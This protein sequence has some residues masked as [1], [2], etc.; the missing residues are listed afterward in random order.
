MRKYTQG[1]QVKRFRTL[2][3]ENSSF[4]TFYRAFLY[5]LFFC[6]IQLLAE[7][8][9]LQLKAPTSRTFAFE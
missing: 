9:W 1:I 6:P 5:N 2:V 4:W 3:F 8:V 7:S